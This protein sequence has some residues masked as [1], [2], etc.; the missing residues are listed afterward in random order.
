VIVTKRNEAIGAV[1][2]PTKGCSERCDVF[3]FRERG[4]SEKSIANRRFAGKLYGRC[5][6]HGQF[7]GGA[8]DT[9]MQEYILCNVSMHAPGDRPSPAKTPAETPKKI[10]PP[11]AQAPAAQLRTPATTPACGL[12]KD[13][14]ERHT[15]R[16]EK[17]TTAIASDSTAQAEAGWGFFR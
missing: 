9:E 12:S 10:P 14:S 2:C 16:P 3:R 1:E 17:Q 8:G 7:G 5:P 4:E 13:R 15:P 6:K 11:P